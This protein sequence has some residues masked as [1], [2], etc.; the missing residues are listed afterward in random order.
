[1]GTMS[2]GGTAD[3]E[4]SA[5]M[6][7]SCREAGV[8]FFDCANVYN[9]G[10]AEE[11]LGDLIR[12]ERDELVITSKFTFRTGPGVN[13]IGSS[14]RNAV[15]EVEK[16][17]KRLKTD[18]IDLYFVHSFDPCTSPEET[19][20][21]LDDLV[22]SGKVLYIGVSNWAAWQIMKALGLSERFG[23]NKI[24]CIQPMYNLVKRQAEVE[25]LPMAKAEK[26]GVI[27]YSPLAGGLLTHKYK[28]DVKPT[29]G[30]F[31]ETSKYL[32]RYNQQASYDS[33]E[34]F[35][36]LAKSRGIDPATLGVAWVASNPA[37]TAPIIGARSNSQL[38]ASL[39]AADL[40]LDPEFYA[41]ISGLFPEPPPATDRAEETQDG[42]GLRS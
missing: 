41:E 5:H 25:I 7:R 4:E 11:I 16:S 12:D 34:A 18:R 38:Q 17:L 24:A 9:K 14:R 27:S 37:I 30:R 1:M 39:A 15:K 19:L 35:K 33:A 20:R 40:S 29:S 13:G 3:K 21:A 22:R 28:R 23:W 10:Q 2:F 26:L 32:P 42:M 36:V 6:Y 31:A 8:N